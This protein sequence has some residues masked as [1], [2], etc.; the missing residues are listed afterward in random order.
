MWGKRTL[1]S[2]RARKTLASVI[3]RVLSGSS[4]PRV[5]CGREGGRATDS[6]LPPR[7][8]TLHTGVECERAVAESPEPAGGGSV[9]AQC[10]GKGTPKNQKSPESSALVSLNFV[11]PWIPLHIFFFSLLVPLKTEF[12]MNVSFSLSQQ[13][14]IFCLLSLVFNFFFIGNFIRPAG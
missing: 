14:N 9:R 11:S 2:R 12:F 1:G 3:L 7:V 10:A 4:L 8:H 6:S 13:L 5:C